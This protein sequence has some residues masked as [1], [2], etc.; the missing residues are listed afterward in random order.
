MESIVFGIKLQESTETFRK[1][2]SLLDYKETHL[3]RDVSL[4]N[5]KK[6]NEC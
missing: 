2:L 6:K 5:K 3:N 1:K 4:K